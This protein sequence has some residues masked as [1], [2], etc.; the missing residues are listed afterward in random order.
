MARQTCTYCGSSEV[1]K[2]VGEKESARCAE[3]NG[4]LP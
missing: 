2:M 4:G 1:K 3:N